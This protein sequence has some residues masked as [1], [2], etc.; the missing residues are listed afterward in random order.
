MSVTIKEK[1]PYH[2]IYLGRPSSAPCSM[3]SKSKTKDREAKQ[4]MPRDRPMLINEP[5]VGERRLMPL[6]KKLIIKLTM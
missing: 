2:S 1:A 5:L 3:K 4:T 6:P